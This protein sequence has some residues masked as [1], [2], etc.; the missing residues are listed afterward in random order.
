MPTA[1][2]NGQR[3]PRKLLRK[4]VARLLGRKPYSA[5]GAV[6]GRTEEPRVDGRSPSPGAW[7]LLLYIAICSQFPNVLVCPGVVSSP[8]WRGIVVADA[9]APAL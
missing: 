2:D 8:A 5:D 1:L 4:V 9:P 7:L 3:S 6:Y